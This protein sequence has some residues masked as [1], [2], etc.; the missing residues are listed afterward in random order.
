MNWSRQE[1]C[2]GCAISTQFCAIRLIAPVVINQV[3]VH[4]NTMAGVCWAELYSELV[5]ITILNIVN[6]LPRTVFYLKKNSQ[7]QTGY[8]SNMSYQTLYSSI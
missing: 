1:C 4:S 8:W 7:Y 3:S 6:E 2:C 5:R